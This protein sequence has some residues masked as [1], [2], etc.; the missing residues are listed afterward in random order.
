L[1]VTLNQERAT[2]SAPS[3]AFSA[4]RTLPPPSVTTRTSLASSCVSA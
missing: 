1:R 4:A 3:I 2:R